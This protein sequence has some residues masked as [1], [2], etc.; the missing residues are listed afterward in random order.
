L[1]QQSDP[2]QQ[3]DPSQNSLQTVTVTADKIPSQFVV[4]QSATLNEGS[5]S[6]FY[7]QL[8]NA[9]GQALR[10]SG[11]AVEEHI[12]PSKGVHTS[13]GTFVPLTDGVA[14]DVVGY[15]DWSTGQPM[16]VTIP[17]D[18]L[19]IDAIFGQTFTVSYGGE[20]FDLTTILQHQTSVANGVVYNT[21][22]DVV[23]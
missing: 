7:Y 15:A 1:L 12:V 5:F 8:E 3:G 14:T 6:Y 11:Y 19:V 2:A 20:E 22:T 16:S 10:G 9:E 21:V 23:P 13:E 4:L 18:A 17:K